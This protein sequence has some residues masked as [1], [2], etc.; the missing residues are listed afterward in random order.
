MVVLFTYSAVICLIDIVLLVIK[1]LLQFRWEK[2]E[3]EKFNFIRKRNNSVQQFQFAFY[4]F[5]CSKR[6]LV[7]EHYVSNTM[8]NSGNGGLFSFL[9]QSIRMIFHS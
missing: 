8:L 4:L 9:E 3:M 6:N 2:Y 7:I 1:L 5:I